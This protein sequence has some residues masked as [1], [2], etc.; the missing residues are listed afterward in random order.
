MEMIYGNRD[1]E[2]NK[3]DIIKRLLVKVLVNVLVQ[4][5]VQHESVGFENVFR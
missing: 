1:F 2:T 5:H 3:R 4:L